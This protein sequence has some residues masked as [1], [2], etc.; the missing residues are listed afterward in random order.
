[1][2]DF[3][4]LT[5]KQLEKFMTLLDERGVDASK[6]NTVTYAGAVVRAA[7]DM[8]WIQMDVDNARPKDVQ[9]IHRKI[10]QYVQD[11]LTVD[12]N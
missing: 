4:E 3:P 12:P 9:A 8:G 10:Q 2:S 7:N 5:Q 6:M 11:A 1:M